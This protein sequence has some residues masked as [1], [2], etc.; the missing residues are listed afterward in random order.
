MGLRTSTIHARGTSER[1]AVLNPIV[2]GDTCFFL[3]EVEMCSLLHGPM[4]QTKHSRCLGVCIVQVKHV[5]IIER[6]Q[7]DNMR[8]SDPSLTTSLVTTGHYSRC[9]HVAFL[10]TFTA[11][12]LACW[13]CI[14]QK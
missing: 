13:R 3:A 12:I 11:S 9:A 2:H 5:K 6:Q 14:S 4:T 8:I 1:R 10:Q 7:T